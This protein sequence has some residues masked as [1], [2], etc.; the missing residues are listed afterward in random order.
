MS[1]KRCGPLYVYVYA[2]T[3]HNSMGQCGQKLFVLN[4][5]L[6]KGT[7]REWQLYYTQM[8]SD[9]MLQWKTKR[10]LCSLCCFFMQQNFLWV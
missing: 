10:Y 9:A 8:N 3:S 7:D 2:H 6:E 4:D 1:T 5:R